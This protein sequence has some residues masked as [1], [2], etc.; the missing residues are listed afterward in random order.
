M[1]SANTSRW[2]VWTGPLYAVV[3]VVGDLLLEGSTPG[4]KA[5]STEVVNYF[6]A[7]RGRTM[8]EVFLA[9]ALIVL[10]ALFAAELRKRA[11]A[12]G[13]DG[14]G[15]AV[16]MIGAALLGGGVVFGAVVDLGL[17]SAADHHQDQ[18]AQTFNVLNNDDWI[19]FIAGLAVFMIGAGS[20]V[21]SA[22]LLP[23][24][25]GWVAIGA[26]VV[27][28]AGPGG[29]VGY[30]LMPAWLIVGGIMLAMRSTPAVPHSDTYAV[31]DGTPVPTS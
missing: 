19:P 30:F 1:S 3:L 16:L 6:N 27:S 12:R 24:W 2:L 22:G 9:P 28:L 5:S 10:V 20:T 13:E 18:I 21:L 11:R 29:F 17:L 23:K 25:L 26:G 31:H 4:E 15:P 7:H 14:I 8:A